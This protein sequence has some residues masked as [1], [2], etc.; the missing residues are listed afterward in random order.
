MFKVEASRVVLTCAVGS[1]RDVETSLVRGVEACAVCSLK[2]VAASCVALGRTIESCAVG[3]VCTDGRVRAILGTRVAVLAG[4]SVL[5][6][7]EVAIL[8]GTSMLIGSEVSVLTCA[9]ATREVDGA[10]SVALEGT[11]ESCMVGSVRDWSTGVEC[12]IPW[13]RI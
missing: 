12:R 5:I 6:G 13:C 9:V 11:V 4:A 8:A 3:S 1:I 7:S 2:V 10:V